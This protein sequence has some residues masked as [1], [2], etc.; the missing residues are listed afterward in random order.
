M[1]ISIHGPFVVHVVSVAVV[2][3]A[4]AQLNLAGFRVHCSFLESFRTP[5]N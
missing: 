2:V 3:V 1:S 5:D 4:R